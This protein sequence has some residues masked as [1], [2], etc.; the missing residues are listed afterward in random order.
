MVLKKSQDWG[1]LVGWKTCKISQLQCCVH[2]NKIGGCCHGWP[3]P[4]HTHVT[5]RIWLA[6]MQSS[7]QRWG[8][9]PIGGKHRPT[10]SNKSR[11]QVFPMKHQ[12]SHMGAV[13]D[14][15]KHWGWNQETGV[16]PY[17]SQW[18]DWLGHCQNSDYLNAELKNWN[19]NKWNHSVMKYVAGSPEKYRRICAK[20]N[21]QGFS[22]I[23][24]HTE[25]AQGSPRRTTY[26]HIITTNLVMYWNNKYI[27]QHS[28][29]NRPGWDYPVFNQEISCLWSG[30]WSIS[31]MFGQDFETPYMLTRVGYCGM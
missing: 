19:P 16:H 13:K 15:N 30:F 22:K 7:W 4:Y 20:H 12:L 18:F 23:V 11:N 3:N 10:A 1:H 8:E 29:E 21:I 26:L 17:E 25:E 6:E 27:A 9:N 2:N 5:N 31:V 14:I 24:Q 28:R